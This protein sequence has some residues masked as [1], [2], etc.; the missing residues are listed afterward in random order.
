MSLFLL[1]LL[2]MNQYEIIPILC[3]EDLKKNSALVADFFKLYSNK[4][5]FPDKDEREA[6]EDI[7]S[8]IRKRP[9]TLSDFQIQSN[10]PDPFTH[11]LCLIVDSELV[12]GC[13]IEFYPDSEAVLITYIFIDSN[14]RGKDKGLPLNGQENSSKIPLSEILLKDKAKGLP[15]LINKIERDYRKSVRAVFFESNNPLKT[16]FDS[17]PPHKRLNFFRKLGAKRVN[18]KYLQ[19]PL[20]SNSQLVD[21]LYLLL[22]PHTHR[23]IKFFPLTT[24]MSFLLEFTKSL[25][26]KDKESAL[27]TLEQY[28]EDREKLENF[29]REVEEYKKVNGGVNLKEIGK[30]FNSSFMS[31]KITD[32]KEFRYPLNEMFQSLLE[33][34]YPGTE[35]LYLSE[36]P[37]TE[38]PIFKFSRASLTIQVLVDEDYFKPNSLILT[39]KN[40][41]WVKNSDSGSSDH[42][43]K[44]L[45]KWALHIFP[46]RKHKNDSDNSPRDKYELIAERLESRYCTVCHSYETDL[47]SY[48]YQ[49]TPPFHT[50]VFA[51]DIHVIIR[52]PESTEYISEGR[53][54]TYLLNREWEVQN[55]HY[56]PRQPKDTDGFKYL[57]MR[58]YMSYSFFERSNI[59]VWNLSFSPKEDETI[60]E[61]TLI[62]LA[63]FFT[64]T[65]ESKSQEDKARGILDK[66]QFA[67]C[68]ENQSL[69]NKKIKDL[70]YSNLLD[71]VF[72]TAKDSG[73]G[74]YYTITDDGKSRY[75]LSTSHSENDPYWEPFYDSKINYKNVKT[76]VIHLDMSPD[77]LLDTK[78]SKGM[79]EDLRGIFRDLYNT[80]RNREESENSLTEPDGQK[81]YKTE[82]ANM[83]CGTTLGI[84]DYDRMGPEEIEDTLSPRPASVSE[85]S[86]LTI[87]R[88]ALTAYYVSKDDVLDAAWTSLGASPYLLIPSAVLAQN[89]YVTLDAENQLNE[90]MEHINT[91]Q[92][93]VNI[94]EII[95]RRNQINDLLNNNY[96]PNVYNYK[97][98]RDLYD[99]GTEHRGIAQRYRRAK[100][101]L[102]QVDI[103]I[104]HLVNSRSNNYQKI[105][106]FVLGVISLTTILTIIKDLIANKELIK[107]T[108]LIGSGL[109]VVLS[110]FIYFLLFRPTRSIL[111]TGN[112]LKQKKGA[113]LKK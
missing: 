4:D 90:L 5:C 60:D 92:S 16:A 50:K 84:F 52:I 82:I 96:L 25:T 31:Y 110:V 62:K 48:Q 95:D 67:I 17:M 34:A 97:T 108:L 106:Q 70:R 109:F 49:V 32:E 44:P 29:N 81:N 75:D 58:L 83:L 46:W 38:E 13:V 103:M 88:G 41:H 113:N 24:V 112:Y 65:P 102:E 21:N 10:E 51:Q 54:E 104:E 18:F 91:Q 69:N 71:S 85:V 9:E 53:K 99:Y 59:R 40:G 27:Y 94:N 76:G 80:I 23:R 6:P 111:G 12:G 63:K 47:F 89:E 7:Q 11:L 77:F 56:V 79:G 28:Q 45:K 3:R 66:I 107:D 35:S 93:K 87:N 37:R 72:P 36:I 39:P 22:Y 30:S 8:R 20:D 98:E 64:G 101:K 43:L 105:V 78:D 86:F 73:L 61:Y 74:V 100:S 68:E 55:D 42:T 19:P 1:F 26:N 14:Y 33:N 2:T 15:W 57:P